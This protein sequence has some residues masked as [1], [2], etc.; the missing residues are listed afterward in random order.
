VK[1]VAIVLAAG[2]SR[3]FGSPKLLAALNGRPMLQHTLDAV[4]AADLDDVV[5]VLGEGARDVEQAI[6]WRGERR[7]LNPRPQDG[8]SSSLRIGLDAA[9]EDPTAEAVLVVLGD[10]PALRPEVV[11][12][13]LAGAEASDRPF[14][15]VRYAGDDAP[16]PVLVRRVAWALAAGLDGDHG[17]GPLLDR[18]PDLVA[19]VPVA[20]R[21]PDVDTPADLAALAAPADVAGRPS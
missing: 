13:V 1:V 2:A 14:V 8:L 6:A 16:N 17:L 5:V 3:R 7:A 4:A 15:R 9:A 10:Q 21:N 18:R 12:A 19:E 11:A 20:G